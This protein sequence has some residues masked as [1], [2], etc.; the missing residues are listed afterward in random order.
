MVV[1][2][3]PRPVELNELPQYRLAHFK[4][5]SW[6][7]LVTLSPSSHDDA[8]RQRYR[9]LVDRFLFLGNAASSD[10][11]RTISGSR[12]SFSRGRCWRA[13]FFLG[14]IALR[15]VRGFGVLRFL[16]LANLHWL[17]RA[18]SRALV[19]AR[20]LRAA[21]LGCSWRSAEQSA[22]LALASN[23]WAKA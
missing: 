4:N 9:R 8:V 2:R 17:P 15:P 1:A 20:W 19:R 16:A 10:P 23:K 14:A 7:S 11:L 3:R 6:I 12:I 21:L 13:F 22:L 5:K 18:G